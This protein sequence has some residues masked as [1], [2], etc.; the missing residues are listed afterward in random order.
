M[1]AFEKQEDTERVF[2]RQLFFKDRKVF[3]KEHD[4]PQTARVTSFLPVQDLQR[5]LKSFSGREDSSHVVSKKIPLLEQ[6][7]FPALSYSKI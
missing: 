2:S 5:R 7:V 1:A 4:N 6:V 3:W